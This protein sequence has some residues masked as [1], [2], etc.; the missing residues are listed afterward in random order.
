MQKYYHHLWFNNNWAE[1]TEDRDLLEEIWV[2][3][4][5]DYILELNR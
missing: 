2:E 4:N 5:Q 3:N 1:Q